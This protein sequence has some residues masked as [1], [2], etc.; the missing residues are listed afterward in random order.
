M[1]DMCMGCAHNKQ[2]EVYFTAYLTVHT[3][4][5]GYLDTHIVSYPDPALQ[6]RERVW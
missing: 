4:S 6:E 3:L 1:E 2:L 5:S